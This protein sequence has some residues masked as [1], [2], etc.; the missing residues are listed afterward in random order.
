METENKA[1]SIKGYHSNLNQ[2]FNSYSKRKKECE[3]NVLK[4]TDD[5]LFASGFETPIL[6]LRS[7]YD[8]VCVEMEDLKQSF[9][10][11]EEVLFQRVSDGV[12]QR[13]D[14]ASKLIEILSEQQKVRDYKDLLELTEKGVLI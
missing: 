3:E 8:F 1:K 6:I 2:Q 7:I 14:L 10:N 4:S 11:D 12:F 9:P 5:L 13:V